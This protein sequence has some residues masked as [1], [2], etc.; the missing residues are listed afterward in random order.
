VTWQDDEAGSRGG[1]THLA[2]L[3]AATTWIIGSNGYHGMCDDPFFGSYLVRFF[4]HFV[5]QEDNGFETTPHVT[6]LHDT[7]VAGGAPMLPLNATAVVSEPSWV[8]THPSFP[9]PLEAV[10]LHLRTGGLLDSAAP[11]SDEIGDAYSYPQ[12]SSTNED[13][14][15]AG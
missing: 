4:D 7:H 13:G 14:L 5:K 12:P 1:Y 9:L 15:L 3:D 2:D 10:A 11:E 6:L 8:T